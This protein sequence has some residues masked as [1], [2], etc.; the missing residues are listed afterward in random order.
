M[1]M[2]RREN[3]LTDHVTCFNMSVEQINYYGAEKQAGLLSRSDPAFCFIQ[4]GVKP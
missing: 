4:E 3:N 1:T 2:A